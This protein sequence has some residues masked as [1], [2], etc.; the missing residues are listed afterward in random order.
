[1]VEKDYRTYIK[2]KRGGKNILVTWSQRRCL[3]CQKFLSKRQEK[4]CSE[5]AIKENREH[6]KNRQR[7]LACNQ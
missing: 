6:A 3:R 4:H 2:H 5:C 7:A 1:M